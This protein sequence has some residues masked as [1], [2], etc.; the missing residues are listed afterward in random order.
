[1]RANNYRAAMG[2]V[3]YFLFSWVLKDKQEI[4]KDKYNI[5]YLLFW[6]GWA[7]AQII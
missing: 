6:D 7:I 1:M 4:M 3:N 5:S 2:W